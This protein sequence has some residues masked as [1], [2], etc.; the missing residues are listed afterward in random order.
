MKEG[1]PV[2][3][4]L[5]EKRRLYVVHA[6]LT[7]VYFIEGEGS[8]LVKIGKTG[9]VKRRLRALQTSSPVSLNLLMT[10]EYDD[11]LESRIHNKL[12]A[13]RA[14]GEWFRIS[15]EVREFMISC[16]D[17]GLPW[18]VSQVGDAP[19]YWM[20]SRRGLSEEARIY[21]SYGQHHLQLPDDLPPK[22]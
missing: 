6:S 13:H 5:E 16:R 8:G 12:S 2:R 17:K 19:N 21:Q 15:D 4:T 18:L 7:K 11:D 1:K 3:L 9:N 14:H 10:I 20:N 22:I